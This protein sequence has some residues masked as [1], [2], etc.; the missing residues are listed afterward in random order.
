MEPD[1]NDQYSVIHAGGEKV[2][3]LQNGLTA[4]SMMSQRDVCITLCFF[5]IL[6]NVLFKKRLAKCRALLFSFEGL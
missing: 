2:V 4:P 3:I 1:A 5:D 6:V